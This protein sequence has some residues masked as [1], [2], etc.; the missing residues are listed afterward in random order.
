MERL[1]PSA[2]KERLGCGERPILLDV[3]EPWEF[4]TCHIEGARNLPM[5][6]M[7]GALHDLDVNAPTVVI[8]H[9]G[10][11]SLLAARFLEQSGFSRIANL[12]GGVDA[13]SREIDSTL[14]RY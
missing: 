11:R 2:L 8:C 10:V 7:A 9:H 1:T 6:R 5:D 3:R 14:P 13:W 4:G 12:E